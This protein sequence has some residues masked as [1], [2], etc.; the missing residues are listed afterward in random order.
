[1]NLIG[2]PKKIQCTLSQF[3][4]MQNIDDLRMYHLIS[5]LVLFYTLS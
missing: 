4:Y 1:M 3:G 2:K 5:I